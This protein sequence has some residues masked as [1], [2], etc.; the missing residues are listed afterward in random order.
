M[1]PSSK[2]YENVVNQLKATN[3]VVSVGAFYSRGQNVEPIGTSHTFYVKLK[4]ANDYPILEQFAN[5]TNTKI[6]KEIPYVPLWYIVEVVNSSQNAVSMSNQFYESN[7]FADVDPAFMFN[8]RSNCSN[9]PFFNSL[10]GLH[11]SSNNNNDIN[12]CDAWG[13]TEGEGVKVAVL[14]TGIDLQHP[15]LSSNIAPISYD[16]QTDTS[17]S[18]I[19]GDSH[20]THV[21]GTIGAVKD[22]NLQ[23]VGV[24]PKSKLVSISHSLSTIV[25]NIS[26]HLASGIGWAVQNGV[27]IINNSWGDQGGASFNNLHSSVLEQ[28]ITNAIISGRNNKGTIVVFSSGNYGDVMDYPATFDNRIITVGAIN[29]GGTRATFFHPR[30]SGYGSKLDVVAPGKYI[31]STV[32]N[33]Y[34]DSN[35]GTSMAAPHVSGVAALILSVNPEL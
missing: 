10:W 21:A 34:I 2:T 27:D 29:P 26:A 15:D 32:N 14:D 25:S 8:F 11:N 7:L 22:N 33:G 4:N 30:S 24:A 5:S 28:T 20:G 23:V 19:R 17:P 13:I 3:G 12:I 6:V 1:T 31:L 35:N 18:I 9:D 16:C